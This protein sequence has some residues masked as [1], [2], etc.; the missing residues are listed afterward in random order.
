MKT[1]VIGGVASPALIAFA[2]KHGFN[3]I[4]I[5]DDPFEEKLLAKPMT[6]KKPEFTYEEVTVSSSYK[7]GPTKDQRREWRR[8]G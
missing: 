2:D 1:I 3:T 6:Y 7:K 5:I 4:S 8:N